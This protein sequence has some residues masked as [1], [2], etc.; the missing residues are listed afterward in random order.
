MKLRMLAGLCCVAAVSLAATPLEDDNF[1]A[2]EFGPS[3]DQLFALK[4]RSDT[5]AIELSPPGQWFR[6][7]HARF[8]GQWRYADSESKRLVLAW[9]DNRDAEDGAA[10][11]PI[12]AEFFPDYEA[13]FEQGGGKHWLLLHPHGIEAALQKKQ[14]ELT[15]FVQRMGYAKREPRIYLRMLGD[16]EQV[17]VALEI[18]KYHKERLPQ[19]FKLVAAPPPPRFL[20]LRLVRYTQGEA[21]LWHQGR[22][23][24]FPL[25][26][27]PILPG[28][29]YKGLSD[30]TRTAALVY[31][32][33]NRNCVS[34]DLLDIGANRSVASPPL[35][36]MTVDGQGMAT[37]GGCR[38]SL[39][40]ADV[41]GVR[42]TLDCRIPPD[43]APL[44]RVEF[45]ARP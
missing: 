29:L 8:T 19:G 16:T 43:G 17:R 23:K 36:N 9:R 5:A 4:P 30:G 7:E 37:G 11:Q 12:G 14:M 13:E 35:V 25:R 27:D 1:G 10:G 44:E 22:E 40:Q 3:L 34:M 41:E 20:N 21:R 45:T 31:C 24:V 33:D 38:V 6:I 2:Y 32:M 15:L 26:T 18:T 42:G 39:E 28:G